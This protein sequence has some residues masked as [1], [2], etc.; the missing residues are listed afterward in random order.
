MVEVLMPLTA[1]VNSADKTYPEQVSNDYFLLD[2]FY[3]V[4]TVC[5]LLIVAAIALIDSGLV[6]RKNTLDMWIQK[7]VGSMIA[8]GMM[9]VV[10]YAIWQIQFYQGFGV[11]DPISQ[12]LKD[13]WAFGPNATTYSHSIDPKVTPEADVFQI[14]VAFFMAFAAVGA[15]LL[16]SAGLERLKASSY[17]VLSFFLGGFIMP[18]VLYY[19]WGSLSPLTNRGVHDY[20]GIFSMYILV[21]VWALIL[22]WRLGPR[23]GTFTKHGKTQGP[24]AQNFAF[25][26]LGVGLLLF[27]APF[28]FLG[29]GYWVNGL[30]YFGINLNQSGFG[31]VTM[32]MF[33][34][35]VGGVVAGALIA[36][37]TRNPLI[38]LLGV[39]AGYISAGAS[40]DLGKPWEIFIVAFLGTFVVWGTSQLMTKIRLDDKKIIPLALGGGVFS[41]LAA[42]VVGAGEKA[43]GFFGLEG[44]YAAFNATIGLGWQLVGVLVT[45][46]IAAV[47]GLIL[48]FGLEKTIGLRVS[49]EAELAGLDEAYWDAPPAP[50][51][52]VVPPVQTAG[53][54]R[55]VETDPEEVLAIS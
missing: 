34:S 25:P 3:T 15:A 1:L 9:W 35:F 41:A 4:S 47:S 13:W 36:Y 24:V 23:L 29:C 12:A 38:A 33:V 20:I 39:P 32:N 43:G 48:I 50:Y 6:R 2:I 45:I 44:E 27:A 28:A 53:R 18:I 7:I 19:T 22:A 42:G 5:L 46:G 14:F 8:A 49:E 30:G 17:Y 51:E 54:E 40:L 21:G 52:D 55:S 11:P 10:G 37:R 16:H 31:I 26:G